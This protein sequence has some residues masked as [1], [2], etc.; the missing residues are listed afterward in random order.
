[1]KIAT[2]SPASNQ[3]YLIRT[4]TAE[5]MGGGG[6]KGIGAL[7]GES[8]TGSCYWDAGSVIV[9]SAISLLLVLLIQNQ[10]IF[11]KAGATVLVKWGRHSG[12]EVLGSIPCGHSLP[13]VGVHF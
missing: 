1:M 6:S 8:D 12:Q 7:D 5:G 3:P 4:G 13:A 2:T 9:S 10:V 11:V